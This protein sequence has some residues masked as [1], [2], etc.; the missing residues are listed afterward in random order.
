MASK[1]YGVNATIIIFLFLLYFIVLFCIV[2]YC[3]VL[4]CIVLYCIVL[5]C[6][7]LYCI[8]LYCIVLYCIVLCFIVFP[9]I[10]LYCIKLCFIVLYCIVLYCVVLYCIV[11][12]Y[13]VSM[14]VPPHL[15]PFNASPHPIHHESSLCFPYIP[16]IL[17]WRDE[18]RWVSMTHLLMTLLLRIT[19]SPPSLPYTIPGF[20]PH[21]LL[22]FLTLIQTSGIFLACFSNL[23]IYFFNFFF[24]SINSFYFSYIFFPS[25][26][27]FLP[28]RPILD[29]SNRFLVFKSISDLLK[30]F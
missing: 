20:F 27:K 6:I 15:E 4:L 2:L 7:V 23:Y 18:N 8:V 21:N 10:V 17:P 13:I 9:C 19:N 22:S 30:F 28:I 12:Y 1:L 29:F 26:K 25:P 16:N 11:L 3:N 24:L 14:H 5:Y